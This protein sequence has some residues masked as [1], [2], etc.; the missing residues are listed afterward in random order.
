MGLIMLDFQWN[1]IEE[2]N[3]LAELSKPMYDKK[4]W[5]IREKCFW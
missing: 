4:M 2:Q 5:D 3:G 1:S